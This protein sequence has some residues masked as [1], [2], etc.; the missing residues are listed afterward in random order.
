MQ[1]TKSALDDVFTYVS[2]MASEEHMFISVKDVEMKF[3]MSNDESREILNSLTENGK[4]QVVYQNPKIKVYAP[5]EVIEQIVRTVKKPKWVENYALPNKEQHLD[6]K[7]RLDQALYEYDRFEELLYLK[8]SLLEEPVMF[9][10]TWL[11]FNV[12]PLPKG[13]Y[14]D[15]ELTKDDFLA[16]VEVAGGNGA[17]SMDEIRQLIQYDLEERKKDRNIP[18]LLVLFNHYAEKDVEERD[19]PFAKNILDAGKKHGVT[20]A[21][22]CQ[23][24]EKIRR[25]KSGEKTETIVEEIMEGKWT[26]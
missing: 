17:C 6:K 15:F 24:Y 5:K 23:L 25:V 14:A 10:F 4:L 7:R 8:T 9:G 2:D 20:L 19:A 16:A 3:G 13:A 18:H 21:T 26:T 12:E 1:K 11:G 22:T